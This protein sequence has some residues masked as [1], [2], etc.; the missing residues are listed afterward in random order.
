MQN[1]LF[2]HIATCNSL[3]ISVD[4][5]LSAGTGAILLLFS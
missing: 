1:D 4:P 2:N 3:I 5:V